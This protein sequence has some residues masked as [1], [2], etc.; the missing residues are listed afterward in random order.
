MFNNGITLT[1]VTIN[2]QSIDNEIQQKINWNVN[3]TSTCFFVPIWQDCFFYNYR[4]VTGNHNTW[5]IISTVWTTKSNK[6]EKICSLYMYTC[7][8]KQLLSTLFAF[9]CQELLTIKFI[10]NWQLL[11]I[12][13]FFWFVCVAVRHVCIWI[14]DNV[15]KKLRHVPSRYFIQSADWCTK[16]TTGSVNEWEVEVD[17]ASWVPVVDG[18]AIIE[19]ADRANCLLAFS[20]S[21]P[22]STSHLHPHHDLKWSIHSFR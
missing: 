10:V 3:T 16:T 5:L 20:N 19:G 7:D 4:I 15:I 1:M 8:K 22:S 21:V 13:G 17:K 14:E 12:V 6:Y 9:H 11:K 2:K 18:K